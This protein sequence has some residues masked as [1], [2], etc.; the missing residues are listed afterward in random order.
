MDLVVYLETSGGTNPGHMV[1]GQEGDG[2]S[3]F[4]GFRFDPLNLP[5]EFRP[6]NR[7]RDYL[8]DHAVP[9]DIVN[10]TNYTLGLLASEA[11]VYVKRSTGVDGL[12]ALIPPAERWQRFALYSFNPDDHTTD[13]APC[14]NCVTWATGLANQLVS[15]FLAPVRQGRV[16]L[17]VSQ[18]EPLARGG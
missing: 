13:D 11:Q 6:P 15:G 17:A 18:L 8:F 5:A 10:D 2:P 4:F 3:R 14:Y 7:W 16:K 1:I 9:G 12:A